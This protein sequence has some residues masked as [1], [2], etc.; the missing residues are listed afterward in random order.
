[1]RWPTSALSVGLCLFLLNLW[2]LTNPAVVFGENGADQYGEAVA[3][4]TQM[5]L[6]AL[7][8]GLYA[9]TRIETWQVPLLHMRGL[10]LLVLG[11]IG[12]WLLGTAARGIVEPGLQ[13][14]PEAGAL[15]LF[16]IA[17][18]AATEESLFRGALPALG[19][20]HNY[21]WLVLCAVLFGLFHWQVSGGN[22]GYM[23]LM[24]VLGM[25]WQIIAIKS[26]LA[27]AIGAHAGW[28]IAVAI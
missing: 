9:N 7:I 3:I 23:L 11:A 19:G 5:A 18:V 12:F 24:M 1:M 6:A 22:V 2:I 27:G 16:Y 10:P 26:G 4:Y 14:A 13:I 20:E 8:I 25:C 28:N 17:V 15:G 21:S